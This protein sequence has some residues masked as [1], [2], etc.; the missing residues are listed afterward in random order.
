M[1]SEKPGT[2]IQVTTGGGF[3]ARESLDGSRLYF[4]RKSGVPGLYGMPATGGATEL[5][6]AAIEPGY[7]AV[8]A[9]GIFF[10]DMHHTEEFE[11]GEPLKLYRFDTR[12][13]IDL[14]MLPAPIHPGFSVRRDGKALRWSGSGQRRSD[15]IV[16]ELEK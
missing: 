14:G 3:A 5:I 9:P 4:V 11:N 2:P 8:A 10:I 12:K 1:E 15:L 16:T 13:I 6:S 7:W